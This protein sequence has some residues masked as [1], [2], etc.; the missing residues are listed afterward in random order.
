MLI[1]M[2][3]ISDSTPIVFLI[4][5]RPDTTK[6]VFEAIRKARPK[7]LLVV[8]DG[9][10]KDRPNDYSRCQKARE[11]VDTVDWDCEVLRNYSDVNLGC[12]IR[13][14]SGLSW[15]FEQVEEAIILEDDCVP[16]L[17]F[18]QFCEELL[19]RYRYDE[20]VMAI[21]G[22]NFQFGD[23]RTAASYYFSRYPH[24][25]GWATWRR[26]W[27]LY[28]VEMSLWPEIRDGGW[29]R[30]LFPDYFERQYWRRIFERTYLNRIDSWAF[31]WTF[32]CWMSNGLAVLPQVNL[33]SNIGFAQVAT[34]TKG[35]QNRFSNMPAHTIQFPLVHPKHLIRDTQADARTYQAM[36]SL[37]SRAM[38]KVGGKIGQFLSR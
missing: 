13:V 8:A 2:E 6:V 9:W 29:M 12:K 10:R 15:V 28:D 19:E 38:Q 20:R 1:S 37:R 36:Y 21:S 31:R 16:D 14:S 30:D 26:A 4:F 33:V 7:K 23:Q 27:Q 18:F 35:S 5:N 3:E 24:C 25:W 17:S 22:D 32:A 11:I 34:H